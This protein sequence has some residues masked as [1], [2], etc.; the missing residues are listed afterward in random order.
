W[1]ARGQD[2]GRAA[3]V[4]ERHRVD[5]RRALADLEVQLRRGDIAGLPRLRDHLT[6]LDRL[7]A[8]PQNFAPVRVGGHLAVRVTDQHEIAVGLELV[9]GIGHPAVLSRLDRRALRHRDVDA[10]V[11]LPAGLGTETGD[12]TAAHRPA[13]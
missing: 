13:E 5:R 7:V 12:D 6:A 10:V 3:L 1:T 4:E 8:L 9:A 2:L 11:L